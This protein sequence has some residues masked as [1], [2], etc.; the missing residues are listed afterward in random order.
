[1]PAAHAGRAAGEEHALSP[2]PFPAADSMAA[3][4]GPHLEPGTPLDA[5]A[6]TAD[7][8][9]VLW[10]ADGEQRASAL[11]ARRGLTPRDLLLAH[12]LVGEVLRATSRAT[13]LRELAASVL[14]WVTRPRIAEDFT[15]ALL[16]V[17]SHERAREHA[18]RNSFPN[19]E[20]H[21]WLREITRVDRA[22]T[23]APAFRWS[24]ALDEGED[25]ALPALYSAPPPPPPRPPRSRQRRR[26][27]AATSPSPPPPSTGTAP[28]RTTPTPT[29]SACSSTP[30]STRTST[31]TSRPAPPAARRTASASSA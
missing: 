3:A 20:A 8:L 2:A 4:V 28:S 11:A 25:L 14:P 12:P 27:G 18:P 24:D 15:T 9:D 6:L 29:C 31:R 10:S 21:L 19:L 22:V 13:E 5:D 30:G 17:L 26:P 23:T 7:V 16:A 1:R